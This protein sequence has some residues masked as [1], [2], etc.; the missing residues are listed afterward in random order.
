MLHTSSKLKGGPNRSPDNTMYIVGKK[1]ISFCDYNTVWDI[2]TAIDQLAEIIH[3]YN[4]IILG[5]GVSRRDGRTLT[6]NLRNIGAYKA[7]DVQ[8]HMSDPAS[9]EWVGKTHDRNILVSS[10]T[11]SAPSKCEAFLII[12]DMCVEMSDY[13]SG[14]QVPGN[15]L[16]EAARQMFVIC[17]NQFGFSKDTQTIVRNMQFSINEIR[18]LFHLFIFPLETRIHLRFTDTQIWEKSAVAKAH[19]SFYQNANRCCE[20]FCE[21]Q[22]LSKNLLQTIKAKSARHA[23]RTATH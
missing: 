21:A 8:E 10:P 6:E 22:A 17:V 9:K 1:F 20:V 4:R 19:I 5:Q 18:A 2:D 12:D 15:V 13:I 14:E 11:Q 23:R 3:M 7:V 16:I